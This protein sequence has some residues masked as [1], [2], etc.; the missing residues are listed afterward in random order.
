VFENVDPG[1]WHRVLEHLHAIVLR[2]KDWQRPIEPQ[3]LRDMYIGKPRDRLAAI[4]GP[5]EL[6]ELVR[7]EGDLVVN[8]RPMANLPRLWDRLEEEVDA[9]AD[10]SIGS[11][12]HGDLCFSNILYDLRSSICKLIDPRGS[13]GKPGVFGDLR[14]DVAKLYHSVHG[15]YDFITADLFSID[16]RGDEIDFRVLA[17]PQHDRVRDEFERVFFLDFDSHEILLLT[18]LIFAS[19]PAL[20]YDHPKRQLAL[21]VRAVE[22]LHDALSDHDH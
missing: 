18:G 11:V 12:I 3:L 4:T 6:L 8:G 9:L 13:F 17:R 20:H 14:Y 21:Y 1:V 2:F 7:H 10:S 16:V 5:P 15:R 19:L 22:L